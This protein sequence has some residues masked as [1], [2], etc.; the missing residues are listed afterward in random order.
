MFRIIRFEI[1]STALI[2][3]SK[4][5]RGTV[6]KIQDIGDLESSN[7]VFFSK[8]MAT[9]SAEYFELEGYLRSLLGDGGSIVATAEEREHS[10]KW[11][12]CDYSAIYKLVRTRAPKDY[13]Y[14]Y[15]VE[16]ATVAGEF[17]PER[18]VAMPA[19]RVE[20]QSGRYSSGMFMPVVCG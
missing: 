13:D 17:G 10:G 2:A 11:V 5:R 15:C 7:G 20:Y 3:A 16:I 9:T 4:E 19:D 12:A 1:D 8:A 14:G 6:E 18:L